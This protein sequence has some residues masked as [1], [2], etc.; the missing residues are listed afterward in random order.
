MT[1]IEARRSIRAPVSVVFTAVT[2]IA[3]LPN[4]NPDFVGIEFLT[5]QTSGIG[6]R[7]RET[8]TMNGKEDVTAQTAAEAA[9]PDL[10]ESVSQGDREAPRPAQ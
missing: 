9:D 1:T 2:D 8:R 4:T 6:T 10:Q 7:F 5:E 3:D